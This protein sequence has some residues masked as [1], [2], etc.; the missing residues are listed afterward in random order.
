MYNNSASKVPAFG[1]PSYQAGRLL[2][3]K[4]AGS[5]P[6]A[7]S[8]VLAFCLCKHEPWAV[9]TATEYRRISRGGVPAPRRD[10][11]AIGRSGA[12][13]APRRRD[14]D[15]ATPMATRRRQ[16]K[17]P[18]F[19]SFLS[20]LSPHLFLSSHPFLP[21]AHARASGGGTTSHAPPTWAAYG[22]GSGSSQPIIILP[23]TENCAF[24]SALL[25]SPLL[26]PPSLCTR[27]AQRVRAHFADETDAA[28]FARSVVTCCHVRPL[29]HRAL[30]HTTQ[31]YYI[32]RR[33]FRSRHV[34]HYLA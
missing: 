30:D 16:R 12:A 33:R 25:S 32:P 1:G 14:A 20:S 15:A 6:A 17:L 27:R 11:A 34:R 21:F 29:P 23:V 9:S 26:S 4:V 13:P 28:R 19:P 31:K 3:V 2:S 22:G 5:S 24:C 18:F 10:A 7:V 8:S